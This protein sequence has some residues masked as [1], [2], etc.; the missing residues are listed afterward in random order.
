MLQV[1]S[2]SLQI[3]RDLP[4]LRVYEMPHNVLLR[5]LLVANLFV[6]LVFTVA[7]ASF[8]CVC[9]ANPPP[10]PAPLTPTLP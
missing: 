4:N 9:P 8:M 3:P 7:L 6:S 10:P 5:V 2:P 1:T